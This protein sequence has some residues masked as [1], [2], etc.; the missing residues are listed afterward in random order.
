MPGTL[1]TDTD[2]DTARPTV[3]DARDD[4]MP[5]IHAIYAHHVVHGRASLEETPP[6]LDEMRARRAAVLDKGLPYLVA[7]LQQDGRPML[8]GY[9]YATTY[10]PR[11]AYRYTVENSIYLDDRMRGRGVGAILLEALLARCEAGP[12]RQ[13]IAVIACPAGDEGEASMALHRRMGFRHAAR[14]EAVGY[15]HG[16]WIDTVLMQR[17]LGAGADTQPQA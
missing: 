14:L 3:R 11:S 6:T 12:W 4:D 15:K 13:M 17:A 10:R 5:A 16:Q 7:E 1:R 2:T 9:A 8:C